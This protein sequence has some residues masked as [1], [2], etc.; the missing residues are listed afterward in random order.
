MEHLADMERELLKDV[1]ASLQNAG[2][3]VLQILAGD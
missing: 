1:P 3:Q 2:R